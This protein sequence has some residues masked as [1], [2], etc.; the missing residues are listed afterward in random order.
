M[1]TQRIP[2]AAFG[3]VAWLEQTRIHLPLKAIDCRFRVI[4]AAVD[5][6]IDQVF[7]QSA[8]RPLDV[9]YSFPLPSK[10]AVYRCEMIVNGRT[11]RAKVVEQE[12]AREIARRKRAEGRRTA[13]VEMERGNLFTLSL[14][15][16]QPDDVIVIRFAYFE[17]LDA[18]KDELALQIPFSPGVRY[19]PGEPLF[20]TNSGKGATDDTD[21][22][23]DASRISP[24][25]IDE[26]HPDAARLSLSG[27]LD[28]RDVDLC[29][30]S[31]PTH[32]TAVRPKDNAFEI[33]LP[34]NA[35]VPDRDFV[36]RWRRAAR[37]NLLSAAWISSD[38][39]ANYALVQLRAP[40]E[41]PGNREGVDI[42]FL[43]DRSGSMSGEK[44]AKTAEALIAFVNAA[45]QR[46]RVWI[47]FFESDYQDFA[48]KPLERDAL[49]RDPNFQSL[50]KLGTDGGTELLP[51]LRH[52][53]TIEQRFSTQRRS[54]VVLITDGQVGNEEAVLQAVSGHAFPAHCFGI[55]HAVNEAFLRQ[56][57]G[58]Q[59]GTCVFLT[60]NDDLVRPIAILGSRLSRPALTDLTLN[61]GW[62]L[63]DTDLPD[64]H[65]GQVVFASIRAAS[66][67]S[68]IDVA[69]KDAAGRPVTLALETQAVETDLPRLIWMKH[70]ID[71]L[72]Q[73]GKDREAVALAEKANLV[74]RGAAFIAWDD[75]EKVPI[76]QNEVYQA[77]FACRRQVDVQGRYH[78]VGA[79]GLFTRSRSLS[80][81]N[82]TEY[83][84]A[85]FLDDSFLSDAPGLTEKIHLI[86]QTR[87]AIESA[88]C[89]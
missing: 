75:A 17:E 44:W 85:P 77:S 12:A 1:N 79:K 2:T 25:R 67:S 58:Q 65:A 50:A 62:E 84:S 81:S 8:D 7:H 5:V 56:L 14:G 28:A 88:F 34:M 24:P 31:S 21:Q 13:L 15:N 53:L 87:R 47:T 32:A 70:R 38:Q 76:A 48:E 11:I 39:E 43:V 73:D 20:R 4:G 41:V 86:E 36:L 82:V 66:R 64:I 33:F 46:D 69:G 51:A 35:A 16:V 3:L 68:K 78:I 26:M 18:W 42:Y 37:P 22:V 55:D 30:I 10:A 72:L 6:E 40:D 29:S 9:T 60:P 54:H 83:R 80:E 63:A 23:P 52:V 71:S 49:L 61:G 74:C 59:R 57:A 19:I 89:A 45:A 27:K